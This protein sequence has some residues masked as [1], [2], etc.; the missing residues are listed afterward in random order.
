MKNLKPNQNTSVLYDQRQVFR[1]LANFFNNARSQVLACLNPYTLILTTDMEA[2][3]GPKRAARARGVKLR[4]ITD[5]TKDNLAYCTR[6][7]ELVDELR[8]LEG[9]KGKFI[10]S[11]S[12]FMISPDISKENP[13]TDA[14]YCNV[15]KMLKQQWY[16]FET[17]WN[18]AV[19]ADDRI[20]E[21]ESQ[22]DGTL[23]S[24]ADIGKKT[25]VI[26]RLYVCGECKATFMYNE[27]ADEHGSL[28]GH[29]DMREFPLGEWWREVRLN[30]ASGLRLKAFSG[31]G[32]LKENHSMILS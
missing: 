2:L 10:L 29:R 5:I 25:K 32:Y 22:K 30:I 26:D 23:Q 21:L 17:I 14:V 8:H 15:D 6:Q 12:E 3:Q 27:D 19:L 1:K 24:D 11:D 18:H 28:T 31:I 13:L 7:K 4:Y 9:I 16:V 20:R